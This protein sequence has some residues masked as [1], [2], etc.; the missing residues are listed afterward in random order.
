MAIT[1]GTAD[2]DWVE[3]PM[4]RWRFRRQ[5]SLR[6]PLDQRSARRIRRYN[7]LAPWSPLPPVVGL[8]AWLTWL[9]GDLPQP[10]RSVA[11]GVAVGY[12]VVWSAL[13]GRGL[14]RQVPFLTRFGDLRVPEVPLEVA[15]EWIAQN[16]GVTATDEPAP[17]P[18]SPRFYG[19]SAVG[20]L[21]AAAGL[22]AVL[23]T[24][25]RED[26]ILLWLLVPVLLV[27]GVSM[28]LRTQP[29][30]KPGTGLTW[31]N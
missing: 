22:F 2:P 3:V 8:L 19:S 12:F 27:T 29:P 28:A 14:S 7:R 10:W 4:S 23:E 24:D 6:L 26:F 13:R 21:V 15:F 1:D 17:R 31:P 25:G 20:L 11:L 9:N 18:H 5:P 30:A 16:P